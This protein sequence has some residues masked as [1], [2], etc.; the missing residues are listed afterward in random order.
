VLVVIT[1]PATSP[2][3]VELPDEERAA[4]R[5]IARARSL[6]GRRVT[7]HWEKARRGEAGRRIVE[8]ARA[9]RARAIVMTPPRRRAGASVLGAT[10]E[11]VLEARPCR[12]IVEMAMGLEQPAALRRGPELAGTSRARA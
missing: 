4:E 7:G 12:V 10:L 5:V 8:E 1:V 9:I 3:D 6:G 11:T 2:I